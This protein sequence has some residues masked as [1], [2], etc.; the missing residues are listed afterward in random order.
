[1]VHHGGAGTVAAALAA[2]RPQVLCPHMGDQTHWAA[3]MRA[4]GVAPAPL[5]ARTL[6]AHGLAEAITAAVKDQHLRHRAGEIA[7]LVR[8]ENGVDAAVNSLA[9]HL[10]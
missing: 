6:T 1:M 5:T 4:L 8:A 7:P 10:T 9:L 3:R 2:G